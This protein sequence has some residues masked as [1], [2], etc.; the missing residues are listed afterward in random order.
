MEDK[1]SF[2]LQMHAV[3]KQSSTT[4]VLHI[5]FDVSAGSTSDRSLNDTLLPG[6]NVYPHIMDE[7]LKFRIH[8][9]G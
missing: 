9:M 6:P 3:V 1:F 7:I 4:S 2:Y 8:T 5:V